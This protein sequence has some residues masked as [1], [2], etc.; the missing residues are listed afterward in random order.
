MEKFAKL[1]TLL[2]LIE[3]D[4]DK[5]YNKGNKAAGIRLRSGLNQIKKLA[6]EMRQD[7]TAIKNKTL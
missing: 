6:Q 7:I 1:K 3:T 2:N 5:F 4:A